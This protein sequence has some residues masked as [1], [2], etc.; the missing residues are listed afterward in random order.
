VRVHKKRS[1]VKFMFHEPDDIRWFKPIE[2]YTRAGRRGRITEA[3]GGWLVDMC[4]SEVP[5][6]LTCKSVIVKDC[7]TSTRLLAE[8]K[9]R[10]LYCNR[11]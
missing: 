5:G 10:N 4:C 7:C 11:K 6:R 1:T 9:Q 2:V 8:A 3:I